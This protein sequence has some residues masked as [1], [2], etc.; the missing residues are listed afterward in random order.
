METAAPDE[1]IN[2][3]PINFPINRATVD[4]EVWQ[5]YRVYLIANDLAAVAKAS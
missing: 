3:A 2:Q 1:I 4:S 5:F